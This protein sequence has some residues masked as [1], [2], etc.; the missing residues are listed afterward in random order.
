MTLENFL[1]TLNTDPSNIQFDDTMQVIDANYQFTP[2]AF[3]NGDVENEAG[4][5]NGSCK[6]FSFAALH[7]LSESQTL[8]CFGHH[9]RES[10]LGD[11]TGDS[12]PNIRSFMK[13]GW[14]GI[15]FAGEALEK[16]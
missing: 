8:S 16:I 11:L 2:T 10:V 1:Q 3:K 4:Q 7:E 12:H 13:N 5:N 6:I 14:Q 15:D 9:Y